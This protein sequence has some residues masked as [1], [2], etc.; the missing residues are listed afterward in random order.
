LKVKSS[1]VAPLNK[2]NK[3][4]SNEKVH[5]HGSCNGVAKPVRVLTDAGIT[6]T[7]D[8]RR[9]AADGGTQQETDLPRI[10]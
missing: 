7:A 8:D 9:D 4:N 1:F 10:Q 5:I 3:Y 6:K 2:F